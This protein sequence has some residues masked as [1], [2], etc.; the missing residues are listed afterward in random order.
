MIKHF[1]NV[2]GTV[3]YPFFVGYMVSIEVSYFYFKTIKAAL[4]L[5]SPYLSRV[6]Y[7][8]AAK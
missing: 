6:K 1:L 2:L 3:L 5:S 8:D 7:H 4:S